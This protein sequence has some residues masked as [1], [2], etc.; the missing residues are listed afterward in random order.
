[1]VSNGNGNLG[2]VMELAADGAIGANVAKSFPLTEFEAA[3][4]FFESG[5]AGGKVVVELQGEKHDA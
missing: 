3:F 4:Q 2:Q 1:M 5:H